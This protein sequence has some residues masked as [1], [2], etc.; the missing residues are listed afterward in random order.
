MH[1]NEYNWGNYGSLEKFDSFSI[2]DDIAVWLTNE[3]SLFG[4][5]ILD[6]G[7]GTGIQLSFLHPEN[8]R[9]NV[10]FS[11]E[12]IDFGRKKHKDLIHLNLDVSKNKLPFSDKFFDFAFSVQVLEHIPEHDICFVLSEIYRI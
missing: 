5:N 10:D 6:I 11:K 8:F 3:Y 7:G 2:H 12:A 1:M 9:C 4:K